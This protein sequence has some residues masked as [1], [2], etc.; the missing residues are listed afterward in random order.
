M[1]FFEK[2][3]LPVRISAETL[4]AQGVDRLPTI[5]EGPNVRAMEAKGFITERGS[6][7]RWVQKINRSFLLIKE[8]LGSLLQWVRKLRERTPKEESLI[9]LLDDYTSGRNLGTYSQKA[10]AENLKRLTVAVDYLRQH[11]LVTPADLEAHIRSVQAEYDA[12]KAQKAKIKKQVDALN[13]D[14]KTIRRW[15]AVRPIG[16]QYEKKTIGKNKFYSAHEKEIKTYFFIKKKKQDLINGKA[17]ASIAKQLQALK[18]EQ[19]ALEAAL[20]PIDRKLQFL[21]AV[22]HS[23]DV[24]LGKAENTTPVEIDG[25]TVFV[26]NT[27]SVLEKLER[28]KQEIKNKQPARQNDKPQPEQE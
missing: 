18:T 10:K 23:I 19:K 20:D 7:N 13:A 8:H 6:Y 2:K 22:Q 1:R 17:E 24:A 9:D 16:E 27:G 14:L 26:E 11:A 25:K 21:K 5:H 28:A 4:E 12:T 3:G 15:E